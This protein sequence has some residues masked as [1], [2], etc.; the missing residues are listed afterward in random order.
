[1]SGGAKAMSSGRSKLNAFWSDFE[2]GSPIEER[3]G[4]GSTLN[5]IAKITLDIDSII[6][7]RITTVSKTI[8]S[9]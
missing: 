9:K 2:R 6:L 3:G 4:G 1:M 5:Q 8:F 7:H